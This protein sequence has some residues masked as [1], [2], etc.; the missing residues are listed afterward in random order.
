M[1]KESA[2]GLFRS[3]IDRVAR[4]EAVFPTT[5]L[6]DLVQRRRERGTKSRGQGL[7]IR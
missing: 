1:R 4:A 7:R 5:A 3:A 6:G 2:K